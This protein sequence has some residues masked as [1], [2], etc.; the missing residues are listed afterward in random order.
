MEMEIV[1]HHNVL[2]YNLTQANRLRPTHPTM[3]TLLDYIKSIP[4][5]LPFSGRASLAMGI[6]AMAALIS[7][8]CAQAQTYT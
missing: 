8:P 5:S 1:T 7:S 3:K 2:D 4:A 6:L